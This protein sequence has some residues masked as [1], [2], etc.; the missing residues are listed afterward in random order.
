VLVTV[1][2]RLDEALYANLPQAMPKL[3]SRWRSLCPELGKPVNLQLTQTAITGIFAD[4]GEGGELILRLADGQHK[5]YSA[6]EVSLSAGQ[7]RFA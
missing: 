2:Q 3:L 6:G 5:V 4:I 1:V 7:I